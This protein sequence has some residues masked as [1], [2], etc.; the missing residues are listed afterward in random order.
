MDKK[1]AYLI[2]IFSI[3]LPLDAAYFREY[4]PHLSTM[5]SASTLV[6]RECYQDVYQ[7]FH[8]VIELKSADNLI[9]E[10]NCYKILQDGLYGGVIGWGE[11]EMLCAARLREAFLLP[12][13]K[14][15]DVLK[16]RNKILMKDSIKSM[17]KVPEYIQTSSV[18]EA[19]SFAHRIGYPLVIKPVLGSGSYGVRVVFN[20]SELLACG[21]FS[22]PNAIW[23]VEE[24]I[25]GD[26]YTVD[27][28]VLEGQVQCLY[29]SKYYGSCLEMASKGKPLGLHWLESNNPLYCRLCDFGKTV[30]E[31]MKPKSCPFHLECFVTASNEIIFCE[32][33][34]RYASNDTAAAWKSQLGIFLAEVMVYSSIDQV[35][36][37]QPKTP[38]KSCA[39][40]FTIPPKK[41]TLKQ[42][43]PQIP[44]QGVV[45]LNVLAREG[46]VFQQ[47]NHTSACVLMTIIEA[48]SEKEWQNIANQVMVAFE[49]S[50]TFE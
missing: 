12:G 31:A 41:G 1:K 16:F 13:P 30:I 24:F 18:I 44:I 6:T 11:R 50:F 49:Q 25:A 34:C 38:S 32:I 23:D 45:K 2:I 33:A 39:G 37:I 7:V 14:V 47:G 27:G 17:V 29:P 43:A 28:I 5:L 21:A 9:F 40:F 10:Q 26:M 42:I 48:D 4:L 35:Y 46:Q 3:E 15:D 22:N 20:E 36:R 8:K 19:L